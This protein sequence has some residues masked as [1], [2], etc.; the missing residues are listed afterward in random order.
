MSGKRRSTKA[1][2]TPRTVVRSLERHGPVPGVRDCADRGEGTGQGVAYA[3]AY[4][5]YDGDDRLAPNPLP[6]QWDRYMAGLWPEL[7][8][9]FATIPA[10]G[11][12]TDKAALARTLYAMTERTLRWLEEIG[13]RYEV[14]VRGRVAEVVLVERRRADLR[15]R[16]GA[17]LSR[18]PHTLD[19]YRSRGEGT[20]VRRGVGGPP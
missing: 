14:Q 10:A 3:A 8:D 4:R 2:P 17:E 5:F 13:V 7:L 16:R 19:A 6:E 12:S 1:A 15:A 20:D 11:E 18:Q 9:M